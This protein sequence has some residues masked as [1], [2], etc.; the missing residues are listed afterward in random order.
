MASN[1]HPEIKAA[2]A[3]S[4][5][6]ARHVP[7][8]TAFERGLKI[9][10]ELFQRVEKE[11]YGGMAYKGGLD[12]KLADMAVSLS[13]ALSQTGAVHARLLEQEAAAAEAMSQAQ[14]NHFMT[15]SIRDQPMS[16]RQ[17]IAAAIL[18]P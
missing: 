16:G 3:Y 1:D 10:D 17:A 7:L 11:L 6:R 9:L 15:L 4:D 8:L 12:K 2:L 5:H 14:K 13:R 18:A